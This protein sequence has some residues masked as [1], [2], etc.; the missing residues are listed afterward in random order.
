[1]K[2]LED[3]MSKNVESSK[4]DVHSPRSGKLLLWFLVIPLVLAVSA[5]FGIQARQQQSQQLAGTTKSLEVQSVNVIHPERGKSSSDLTLPG[6]IQA[7][8]QSPIYARVDGYVRHRRSCDQG[9]IARRDRCAGSGPAVESVSGDAEKR[10]NQPGTCQGHGA[11]LPGI[12]QNQ[13]RVA[14]RG[15][16]E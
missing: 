15:G 13:F 2:Q 4:N 3:S 5:L 1:M 7:F 8:S 16:P 6:M 11:S 12:D 9:S 14:T 10:R